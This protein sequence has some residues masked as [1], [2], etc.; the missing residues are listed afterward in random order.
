MEGRGSRPGARRSGA[1]NG[2]PPSG[3][4]A[5]T[6]ARSWTMPLC[7]APSVASGLSY[8]LRRPMGRDRAHPI[9][10]LAARLA[11]LF[12]ALYARRLAPDLSLLGDSAELVTAAALWGVPHPPGYP[13]FTL[14][15]HFFASI[16]SHSLP[17]RVH[18]TSAVF[19]AGAVAATAFAT[20]T[21]TRSRVAALAA[22]FGLGIARSFLLG[23][24]Y[25]EV[26]A[27]ND[28]FTACLFA[29]AF[30][31]RRHATSQA[32]NLLLGFAFWAGFALAHHLMFVL[33][34]PALA[35]LIAR[36]MLASSGT[37]VRR[38]LER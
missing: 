17:W 9:A 3:R 15:G 23:S 24:L 5:R 8:S 1:P 16:P 36:P 10:P 34:A 4:L 12:F 33:A 29:I 38:L 35:S 32:R 11:W 22:G 27:L 6:R 37:D 18:L 28:L 14:I 26:F 7:P 20:F 2:K 19:H 25:A 30:R 13:L 21:I 31:I